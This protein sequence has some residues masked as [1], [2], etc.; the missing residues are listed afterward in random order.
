MP[1]SLRAN[2]SSFF[3]A[4]LT[5]IGM[6]LVQVYSSSY[7]YA[8]ESFGDG[9]YFFKKQ[10]FFA[11]LAIMAMIFMSRLSYQVLRQWS[12]LFWVVSVLLLGMTFIP[13]LG[14]KVGGATRWVDLPLG[15]R[16]EPS[17]FLKI[18]LAT[19]LA[20]F[21]VR[22]ESEIKRIPWIPALLLL[23]IPFAVLLRQ[24][25]FGSFAIMSLVVFFCL[26]LMGLK[27]R[28][29]VTGISVAI[30]AFYILVMQ[31]PYRRAR[32]MAFL[33][34][35]ADPEHKGF[36]VIQSM[37]SFSQGGLTGAG[38]GQGQG[39]LFFLPEAHTDFTLA[40]LGEEVGFI[41][42]FA[43]MSIYLL[44]IFKGLK[45]AHDCEDKFGRVLA[46][47][48]TVTFALN[49]LINAGVVLGLLPTKGLTMPFLSYGGSSLVSM[50]ILFG[51]L[52]NVERH[53][54]IQHFR[55]VRKVAR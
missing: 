43:M 30:P 13:G 52:I 27:W 51:L 8:S 40:V 26:L 44:L 3:L 25:D 17:E 24:P 54:M 5:L 35:W 37:I 45:L 19:M 1:P 48:L 38:L 42:F 28:Y 55:K 47:S 29:I 32:V 14:V 39:K 23:L 49:V 4:V 36:Q 41:G 21:A 50:G 33:D 11:F 46:S 22:E 10:L 31:V 6:G 9:M 20:C 2:T 34:P 15:F 16:F 53:A 7:I 12:W 18:S